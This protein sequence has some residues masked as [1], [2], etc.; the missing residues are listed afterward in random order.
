VMSDR[1]RT[2]PI[3]RRAAEARIDWTMT[4]ATGELRVE[5]T[6][7]NV[8]LVPLHV[9]DS[10]LVDAGP[11]RFAL[12][13]GRLVV[14]RGATPVEVKLVLGAIAPDEPRFMIY[15]PRF[16]RVEPG[17]SFTASASVPLPLA[18]WH[19]QGGALP[20]LAPPQTARLFVEYFAGDVEWMVLES[21]EKEPLR[22]PKS[23]RGAFA[24][25][26]ARPIPGPE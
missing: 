8:G 4:R 19:N 6:I 16:R 1:F 24:S 25:T 11:N 5:H 18:A 14:L 7:T 3:D 13:T 2:R 9:A 17:Q 15:R 12:A 22:V 26:E 10:L 21:P 20:L 23:Y